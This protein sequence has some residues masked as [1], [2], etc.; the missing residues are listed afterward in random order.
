ML[1]QGR[2]KRKTHNSHHQNCVQPVYKLS[3]PLKDK[4]KI[5]LLK[6]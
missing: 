3:F 4:Q 2:L 6:I 5:I 1:K